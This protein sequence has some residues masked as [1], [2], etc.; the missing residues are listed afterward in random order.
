[1]LSPVAQIVLGFQLSS[2][3]EPLYETLPESSKQLLLTAVFLMTAAFAL[4]LWPISYHQI[5]S[6]CEPTTELCVFATRALC[7]S[8]AP[9]GGSMSLGLYIICQRVVGTA[10]GATIAIL[11]ALSATLL[12][13]VLAIAHREP[14][15]PAKDDSMNASTKDKL[16]EV[17]AECRVALPGVQALLGFQ[18]VTVLMTAFDKL[19]QTSKYAHLASMLFVALA[20]VFMIAPA[21]FHR[22]AERGE[23][24]ERALAM[25]SRLL[26]IALMILPPGLALE[27]YVVSLK[28]TESWNFAITASVATGVV[29]YAMWFAYPLMHRAAKHEDAPVHL[30]KPT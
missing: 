30:A 7:F 15:S 1:M 14:G 16:S 21:A 17:L 22:I 3:F 10:A 23:P 26:L 9:L 28:V 19:P 12:W 8:L 2:F 27:I 25:G 4:L 13:Y 11:I 6:H 20:A 24:T 18:T 29:F 5:A